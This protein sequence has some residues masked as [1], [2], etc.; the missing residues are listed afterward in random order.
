MFCYEKYL[1]LQ[2]T[3][4]FL[5]APCFFG[6]TP[7]AH[8]ESNANFVNCFFT[9]FFLSNKPF[10]FKI[11]LKYCSINERQQKQDKQ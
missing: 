2:M 3:F 6:I 8:I 5:C 9:L 11:Y 7:F 10:Y 4:L 1:S